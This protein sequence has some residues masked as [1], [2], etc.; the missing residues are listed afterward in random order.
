MNN[1]KYGVILADPP[2]SYDNQV[3]FGKKA[4]DHYNTMSKDD[5]RN[6]KIPANDNCALFLWSVWPELPQAINLIEAWG[7]RYV[8]IGFIWAKAKKNGFGFFT[9]Q[10][11]HYTKPNTE[12]CLFA[13][14]GSMP[15]IHRPH[16]II[17]SSVRQHS[18]KPEAIHERIDSMYP[19]ELK[20]ELFARRTMPGWDVFG[21]EVK[22]SI[23]LC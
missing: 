10:M 3:P 20:L 18:K 1:K 16:S 21:N 17:Y 9:N 13:V 14:K 12:P 7:F 4:E 8:T 19:D 22:D 5:L 15:P 2:W 6:I 11:G 23:E